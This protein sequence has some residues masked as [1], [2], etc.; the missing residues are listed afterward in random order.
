[1]RHIRKN[2]A[3]IGNNKWRAH[4]MCGDYAART[5][6]MWTGSW[7][8]CAE[9]HRNSAHPAVRC[10]NRA[11]IAVTTSRATI[12]SIGAIAIMV[13]GAIAIIVP[14]LTKRTNSGDVTGMPASRQGEYARLT[15]H[16]VTLPP[17]I[18]ERRFGEFA[19]FERNEL[20]EHM[21]EFPR[22]SRLLSANAERNFYSEDR[23][24]IWRPPFIALRLLTYSSGR[25]QR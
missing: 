19:W 11:P 22:P 15:H 16:R 25:C 14:D 3:E 21:R 6:P 1:M 20:P 17:D 18:S 8:A 9:T 24:T 12:R 13:R 10:S 4:P 23:W 7:H 5:C 2:I